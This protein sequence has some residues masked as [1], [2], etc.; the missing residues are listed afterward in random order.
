MSETVVV[1]SCFA[2][3][4]RPIIPYG[5]CPV[6]P[7]SQACRKVVP[8]ERISL[9]IKVIKSAEIRLEEIQSRL[10]GQREGCRT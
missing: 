9:A 3:Y 2:L 10:A 7:Y 1:P 6:C 4:L 5:P 8:A